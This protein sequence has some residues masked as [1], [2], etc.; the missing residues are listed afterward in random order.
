[1]SSSASTTRLLAPS[2]QLP[3]VCKPMMAPALPHPQARRLHVPLR[4][5]CKTSGAVEMQRGVP[6][7]GTSLLLQAQPTCHCIAHHLA[8]QPNLHSYKVVLFFASPAERRCAVATLLAVALE[9]KAGSKAFSYTSDVA[10]TFTGD[11]NK[12]DVAAAAVAV[13]AYV[14][15]PQCCLPVLS[16]SLLRS[17]Q[18]R[19]ITDGSEVHIV[20]RRPT[21]VCSHTHHVPIQQMLELDTQPDL[22][23][24]DH[25]GG[26]APPP[27]SAK[28]IVLLCTATVTTN[29]AQHGLTIHTHQHLTRRRCS[30]G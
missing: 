13:L 25:L 21:R 4:S 1:M 3:V 5:S 9:A 19:F 6:S 17:P 18:Y 28:N 11:A 2:M 16:L 15:W 22:V 24:R 27:R 12:D 8:L 23:P 20:Q 14:W 10:P 29:A 26:L 7:H 30:A